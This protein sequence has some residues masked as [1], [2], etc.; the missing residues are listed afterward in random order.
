[1]T[2]LWLLAFVWTLAIELPVWVLVLAPPPA[3]WWAAPALALGLNALTHPLL[4]L[5]WPIRAP[6]W[7]SV[8]TGEVA[9]VVVEAALAALGARAGGWS[10]R[11]AVL[12]AVLANLASTLFGLGLWR[13]WP[14]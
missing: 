1:M 10:V 14:W 6:Y 13:W 2:T 11:R 3:R 4:W 5:A 9:V 7:W 12:A 8:C